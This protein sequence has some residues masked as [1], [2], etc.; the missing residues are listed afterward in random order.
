[1]KTNN[2]QIKIDWNNQS[3]HWWNETCADIMETFGLPGDR[4]VS[5][6][7]ADYMLFT[8][9]NKKDADLCRILVSEK[10]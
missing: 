5:S 9:K 2:N 8:F 6:P 7:T 1:M 3:G 4:Y 10:I